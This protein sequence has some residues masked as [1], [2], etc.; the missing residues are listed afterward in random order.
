LDGAAMQKGPSNELCSVSWLSMT[1]WLPNE[2]QV[3]AAKVTA[4][5]RRQLVLHAGGCIPSCTM[6]HAESVE[7]PWDWWV[8][9]EATVFPKMIVRRSDQARQL[10][11]PVRL[12][13][14]KSRC[15]VHVLSVSAAH[16]GFGLFAAAW[17]AACH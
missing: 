12:K 1:V 7:Q 10:H 15:L 6:T 3:P 2:R 5:A 8:V 11:R 14:V 4:D 9:V 16:G 13:I 17:A